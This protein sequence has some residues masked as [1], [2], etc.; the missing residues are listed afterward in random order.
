[1]MMSF[2]LYMA[3]NLIRQ[4]LLVVLAMMGNVLLGDPPH[5]YDTF[6]SHRKALGVLF[7]FNLH[8]F[9]L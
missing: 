6:Y 2:E 8:M 5:L 7:N 3:V 9:F 1:M 4:I